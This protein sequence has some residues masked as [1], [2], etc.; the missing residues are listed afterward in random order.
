MDINTFNKYFSGQTLYGDNFSEEEIH[1]WYREEKEAYADL[2]SK[3]K[4]TYT[5]VYH[6]LN[7]YHGFRFL[8]RKDFANVL[9][10]GSAY[11]EE[12]KPIA[13]KI[14]SLTIVDSSDALKQNSVSGIP[15]DYVKPDMGGKLPFSDETFDL[16]TCLGTLHHIPNVSFVMRDLYRCL[17]E[18]GFL[19]LREPIFSMGDWR[20]PRRGLT[21][22]E[23]GIPLPLLR[24]MIKTTGFHIIRERVCFFPLIPR[25]FNLFNIYA[26]NSYI[27]TLVD[28][29]FSKLLRWNLTYHARNRFKQIRPTAVFYVLTKKRVK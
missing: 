9:G 18:D 27:L 19:L 22:N 3:D 5:Y 28:D 6:A 13:H 2:G 16:I 14:K 15:I 8:P 7:K 17:Q 10:F 4:T 12:F 20:K 21:K 11:G 25:F 29:Y 23:R 24:K 26:Y 1:K